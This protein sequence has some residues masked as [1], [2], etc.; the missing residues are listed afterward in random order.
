MAASFKAMK[1]DPAYLAEAEEWDTGLETP[2][3]EK[4]APW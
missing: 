4:V 1:R 2:L 3:L